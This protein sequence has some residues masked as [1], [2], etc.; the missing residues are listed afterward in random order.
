MTNNFGI[1][2]RVAPEPLKKGDKIALVTPARFVTSSL[3]DD[4]CQ[5]LSKAGFT[6]HISEGLNLREGQFGGDDQSRSNQLNLAFQD[7]DIRAVLALRGGYGSA[8]LLPLLD[9]ESYVNDPTWIVGFSDITALHAW[10]NNLGIASLHA[11]VASTIKT[12]HGEDVEWVWDTLM[13][14]APK[15]I[16]GTIVG[17]NLS[18]LYSLLGTPY[19]PDCTDSFLFIEDLDEFLYHIDRM[20]VSL[21]LAG[22]FNSSKGLMVG[23]FTE[24]KDNTKEFGQSL[25]NPFGKDYQEIILD[26]VPEGYLVKFDMPV[27]HG[28]RNYPII[29]GAP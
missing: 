24:L 1:T 18:V 10:S 22:V 14:N 2:K 23:R 28:E 11:S 8:R 20:I 29:L 12:T 17:G 15:T 5:T 3:I 6:P 9:V 13:G 26:H 19:F 16:D 27:G 25:D 7:P 4:A 21:K